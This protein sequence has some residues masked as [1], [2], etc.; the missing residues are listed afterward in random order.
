VTELVEREL[1]RNSDT[2]SLSARVIARHDAHLVLDSCTEQ[3][4]PRRTA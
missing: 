3:T 2:L 1:L 4:A